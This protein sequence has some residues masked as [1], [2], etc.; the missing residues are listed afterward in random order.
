MFICATHITCA[1]HI[2]L[3]GCVR[4]D[5]QI[6]AGCEEVDC[7]RRI[8]ALHEQLTSESEYS[9]ILDL[10]KELRAFSGSTVINQARDVIE[11]I[12]GIGVERKLQPL[13]EMLQRVAHVKGHSQLDRMRQVVLQE[14]NLPLE[15]SIPKLADMLE[16]CSVLDNTAGMRVAHAVLR[17]ERALANGETDHNTILEYLERCEGMVD[18]EALDKARRALSS[19]ATLESSGSASI[20]QIKVLLRDCG[21]VTGSAAVERAK[22]KV[23]LT[24]SL[25]QWVPFALIQSM[26]IKIGQV[27]GSGHTKHALVSVKQRVQDLFEDFDTDHSGYI[28]REEMEA[29][30]ERMGVRLSKREINNLMLIA[31]EDN[32]GEIDVLE[33]S[34]LIDK[35]LS[36]LDAL[37]SEEIEI[38]KIKGIMEELAGAHLNGED[39]IREVDIHEVDAQTIREARFKMLV[40]D[41]ANESHIDTIRNFFAEY[42]DMLDVFGMIPDHVIE[43]REWI[44]SEDRIRRLLKPCSSA[45]PLVIAK[46]ELWEAVQ[47]C[48]GLSG[49][50]ALA[51]A[52][53]ILEGERQLM[54]ETRVQTLTE[55]LHLC[56][57]LHGSPAVLNARRLVDAEA[58]LAA[59]MDGVE[60]CTIHEIQSAVNQC[61]NLQGS[62]VIEVARAIILAEAV[63]EMETR[64][65]MMRRI[66]SIC[67][68][69]RDSRIIDRCRFTIATELSI[70]IKEDRQCEWIRIDESIQSIVFMMTDE[71]RASLEVARAE[72]LESLRAQIRKVQLPVLRLSLDI[73]D[74]DELWDVLQKCDNLTESP[75]LQQAQEI[76]KALEA[77]PWTNH[78]QDMN[79]MKRAIITEMGGQYMEQHRM[80]ARLLLIFERMDHDGSGILDR[81]QIDKAFFELGVNLLPNDIDYLFE[82]YD[83]DKSGAVSFDEFQEMTYDLLRGTKWT[84]ST[85][86]CDIRRHMQVCGHMRCGMLADRVATVMAWI[87][88]E[89]ELLRGITSYTYL[90]HVVGAC[91]SLSG[92]DILDQSVNILKASDEVQY[93]T[94]SQVMRDLISICGH[95]DGPAHML[96][97]KSWLAAE[98]RLHILKYD[99]GFQD[100]LPCPYSDLCSMVEHCGGLQESLALGNAM[101]VLKAEAQLSLV[102]DVPTWRALLKICGHVTK[103]TIIAQR[104]ITLQA[105]AALSHTRDMARL[106]ELLKEC[107]HLHPC[108]VL[109]SMQLLL[110]WDARLKDC[111][112]EEDLRLGISILSARISGSK[113]VGDAMKRYSKFQRLVSF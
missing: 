4:A 13:K 63:L 24:Q 87:A 92:S 85:D 102:D 98:E 40:H 10:L 17:A 77:L 96:E 29:A 64:S 76:M 35:M 27:M 94:H 54:F 97:R 80:S 28:D 71:M 104:R 88:A 18:S 45:A 84:N 32:T 73:V 91:G 30:F 74:V 15:K 8:L 90:T 65:P 100:W 67:E 107:A 62:G 70:A 2:L 41:L 16:K 19:V 25:E 5:Y 101:R 78:L 57:V 83:T 39:D 56:G 48:R 66:L 53:R 46:R 12:E 44:D 93:A 113:N 86:S 49:S 61:D 26:A 103:S 42:Q 109:K 99:K 33:F 6:A 22:R 34:E 111:Y 52:R 55:L 79:M 23:E 47:N 50:L 89:D 21:S 69:V 60:C 11:C 7:A 43:K 14:A 81:F 72:S 37:K 112:S 108:Y 1:T 95:L 59:L 68:C 3:S 36:R 31:D 82:K 75:V 38:Q 20:K 51:R 105:H 106:K 58:A 110:E 9:S